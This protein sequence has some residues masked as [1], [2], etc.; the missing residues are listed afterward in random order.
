MPQYRL[1]GDTVDVAGMMTITG[2]G[3]PRIIWAQLFKTAFQHVTNWLLPQLWRS[4][5]A[6]RRKYFSTSTDLL[7][8]STAG[9]S[10]SR[11]A[12]KST[13]ITKKHLLMDRTAKVAREAWHEILRISIYIYSSVQGKG[14]VDTYWLNG[15]E[16]GLGRY[17]RQYIQIKKETT[18]RKGNLIRFQV[19]DVRTLNKTEKERRQLWKKAIIFVND[20]DV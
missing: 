14:M 8:P 12:L 5:S 3:Q 18:L 9:Q 11:W 17:Y 20:L 13:V 7:S 10:R 6:W 2:E 16:G 15:R 1:F 4:I 19:K